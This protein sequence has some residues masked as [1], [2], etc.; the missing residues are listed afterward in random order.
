MKKKSILVVISKVEDWWIYPALEQIAQDLPIKIAGLV[1][2]GNASFKTS[3]SLETYFFFEDPRMIGYL[4]NL[5]NIFDD[6]GLILATDNYSM[7]SFQVCRLA[8]KYSIPFMVL[9]SGVQFQFNDAKLTSRSI[10]FDI[11][12]HAQ[13]FIAMSERS[14]NILVEEGVEESKILTISPSVAAVTPIGNNLKFRNY[15]NIS[16]ESDVIVYHDNFEVGRANESVIDAAKIALSGKYGLQSPIWILAGT[17]TNATNLKL[18]ASRLELKGTTL[19]L[20]QDIRPFVNDL[21]AA[22]DFYIPALIEDHDRLVPFLGYAQQAFMAG[23]QVILSA[24]GHQAEILKDIKIRTN[25]TRPETLMACI[26]TLATLREIDTTAAKFR[27]LLTAEGETARQTLRVFLESHIQNQAPVNSLEK[28]LKDIEEL[29]PKGQYLDAITR[30]DD[31]MLKRGITNKQKGRIWTLKGNLDVAMGD[32]DKGFGC[33]EEAL[34][35]DESCSDAYAGLGVISLRS[36]ASDEA[37]TFFGKA[38]AI[39]PTKQSVAVGMATACADGGL[40]TEAIWW[41]EKALGMPGSDFQTTAAVNR[42]ASII[43]DRK[44]ARQFLERV[45]ETIGDH[46][47]ILMGLGRVYIEE[48]KYEKGNDLIKLALDKTAS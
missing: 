15:L 9:Y 26:N 36:K 30:L 41:I 43:P 47:S 35:Y 33:Y 28:T 40:L 32:F 16:P 7:S 4:P 8:S 42:I 48:G 38:H 10:K 34:S 29:I 2:Q 46:P 25:G 12:L 13:K 24:H 45:H 31:V 20:E 37:L 22:A 6:V 5:E 19:F 17:G 3:N 18:K 27:N 39:D 11:N 44:A 1:S 21:L 14:K 23:A